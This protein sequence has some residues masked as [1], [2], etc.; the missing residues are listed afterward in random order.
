VRKAVAGILCAIGIALSGSAVTVATAN[1]ATFSTSKPT[2]LQV[3]Q[4]SGRE[5]CYGF[6]GH[7]FSICNSYMA[8]SY[9][10]WKFYRGE[11][12]KCRLA[13][14]YYGAAFKALVIQ[15]SVWPRDVIVA[16][17]KIMVA[18]IKVGCCGRAAKLLTFESWSVRSFSGEVL[19]RETHQAH[20]VSMR[21]VKGWGYRRWVVTSV[22]AVAPEDLPCG[23]C[24]PPSY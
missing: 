19:F 1:E 11:A 4:G 16:R 20:I 23:P 12:C 22:H 3:N 21:R 7:Y 2:A 24:G 5:S 13:S 6:G 15:V 10:R 14:R 18:A 8:A 9:V 17:P